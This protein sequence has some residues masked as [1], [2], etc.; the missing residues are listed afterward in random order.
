MR[1]RPARR[2]MLVC[3]ALAWGYEPVGAQAR[4]GPV[5][6]VWRTSLPDWAAR[7]LASEFSRR[8]PRVIVKPVS[9]EGHFTR[10]REK[11]VIWEDTDVVTD[12]GIEL[13]PELT[14]N[15]YLSAL[16]LSLDKAGVCS[17]LRNPSGYYAYTH[18]VRFPLVF[19]RSLRREDEPDSLAALAEPRW[20][21]EVVLP[22]PESTLEAGC[23][24]RFVAET[25]GLGFAWLERMRNNGVMVVMFPSSVDMARQALSPGEGVRQSLRK[26]G[27]GVSDTE[28]RGRD[29]GVRPGSA[30]SWG[31][32][33]RGA[34]STR[35][36]AREGSPLLLY[37]TAIS[38]A[39]AHPSESRLFVRWLI[40][41]ATQRAMERN[42]ISHLLAGADCGRLDRESMRCL[43]GLAAMTPSERKALLERASSAL[44]G[45]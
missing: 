20:R 1:A 12:I 30:T 44:L 43:R 23:L 5:T 28:A 10:W 9:G 45:E 25:P 31:G 34:T 38:A 39:S 37:A 2:L 42:S 13:H 26:V 27:W 16:E 11:H 21:R 15:G 36:W 3:A 17:W 4:S 19:S 22:D 8:Y 18:A 6:L 33:P 40:E 41:P 29:L 32:G 35:R 7:K 14:G 24:Y